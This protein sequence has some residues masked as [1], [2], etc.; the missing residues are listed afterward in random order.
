MPWSRDEIAKRVALELRPGQVVNLGEGIPSRI[1]GFL[2]SSKP[3]L[4]FSE[5]GILGVGPRPSSGRASPDVTNASADY[6]G[7][8][9]GGSFFDMRE[10]SAIM[11][12]GHIDVCVVEAAQVDQRGNL[13]SSQR[14]AHLPPGAGADLDLA[15]GARRLIVATDHRD[16]SGAP[17][18]VTRCTS[19]LTVVG[20]VDMVVTDLG[21][22]H[23]RDGAFHAV[24]LAPD[25]EWD[26]IVAVTRADLRY[27]AAEAAPGDEQVSPEEEPEAEPLDNGA[28]GNEER[29]GGEG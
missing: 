6:V 18:L 9:P 25:T 4:I 5:N 20:A 15:F 23:I 7:V 8:V 27:A 1:P 19:P 26:D 11:R 22:F 28:D 14:A 12:G 17:K 3:V 2:D 24:E 21:V 13:A 29:S 16:E 10:S